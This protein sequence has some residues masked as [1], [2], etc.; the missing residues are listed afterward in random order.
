MAVAI[1]CTSAA[2]SVLR[3]LMPPLLPSMARWMPVAVRF[4]TGICRIALIGP[5]HPEHLAE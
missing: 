3:K 4:E 5:W 2:V 1:A